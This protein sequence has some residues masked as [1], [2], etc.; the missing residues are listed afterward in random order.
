MANLCFGAEE[1]SWAMGGQEVV[2]GEP[3]DIA[4]STTSKSPPSLSTLSH[5]RAQ[6]CDALS[7]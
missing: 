3:N 2:L 4:T 5:T 6:C 1:G 7:D